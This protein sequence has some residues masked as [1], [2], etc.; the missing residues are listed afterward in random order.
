[1]LWDVLPKAALFDAAYLRNG[2][3]VVSSYRAKF[4][5]IG[6]YLRDVLWTQLCASS[7]NLLVAVKHVVLMCTEKKVVD[8]Y[9][10]W[11]VASMKNIQPIG[12]RTIN[13]FPCQP[14]SKN[15]FSINPKSRVSMNLVLNCAKAASALR[16]EFTELLK[17]IR[18]R[19]TTLAS[20]LE[21]SNKGC[22]AGSAYWA[23]R[24]AT[25][26]PVIEIVPEA[27]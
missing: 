17:V 13:K 20:H 3:A 4:A 6:A 12:D 1:M 18:N 14:M 22:E 19:K 8:V 16:D 24:G 9:A 27:L 21:T 2:D 11:N 5:L 7:A 23:R 25:L 10:A 26:F 15:S